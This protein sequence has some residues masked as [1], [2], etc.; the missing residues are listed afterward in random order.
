MET[1][2]YG[3][4]WDYWGCARDTRGRNVYGRVLIHIRQR[5]REEGS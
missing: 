1:S 4:Y 3:Y 2:Q 5:P